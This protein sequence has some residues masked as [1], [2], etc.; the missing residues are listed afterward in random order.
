MRG[1][2]GDAFLR[3]ALHWAKR[4]FRVFPVVWTGE[5][6]GGMCKATRT[7]DSPGKHP[8]T[9]N[10][11]LG[12]TLDEKQIGAWWESGLLPM[13]PLRANRQE[14]SWRALT[15]RPAASSHTKPCANNLRL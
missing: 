6:G 14:S 10:G 2:Q 4:E 15:R 7:C 9:G 12:A 1:A 11:L 8:L 5:D 13:S 3:G